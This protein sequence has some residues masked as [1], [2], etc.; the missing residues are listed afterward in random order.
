[1]RSHQS[2]WQHNRGGNPLKNTPK[3]VQTNRATSKG[4]QFALHAM[5][6]PGN[7]YDGHSLKDV[8]PDMEKLIGN[9]IKRILADGKLAIVDIV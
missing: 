2:R 3:P 9:D 5:A 8:I 7:P 4:G 6:L 1:M